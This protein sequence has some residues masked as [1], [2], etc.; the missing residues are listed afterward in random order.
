MSWLLIMSHSSSA[1]TTHCEHTPI[2]M[3]VVRSVSEVVWIY[4]RLT[5]FLN[6][7]KGGGSGGCPPRKFTYIHEKT[8]GNLKNTYLVCCI[9][10]LMRFWPKAAHFERKLTKRRRPKAEK[11]KNDIIVKKLLLWKPTTKLPTPP[12]NL[13]T[14]STT[15]PKIH[16]TYS[17]TPPKILPTKWMTKWIINEHSLI[18]CRVDRVREVPLAS[19]LLHY[20]NIFNLD[21]TQ[22]RSVS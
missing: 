16:T 18:S 9:D 12:K 5:F 15:P 20:W 2:V 7:S 10:I 19:Q 4:V 13:A 3:P 22:L 17:M 6:F 14:Y 1:V 8:F 21:C 11:Q